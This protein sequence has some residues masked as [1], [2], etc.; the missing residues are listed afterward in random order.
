MT[1]VQFDQLMNESR[2]LTLK[3]V[4][5]VYE[6]FDE[7][8]D[9]IGFP[10]FIERAASGLSAGVVDFYDDYLVGVFGANPDD[11]LREYDYGIDWRIWLHMPT[12]NERKLPFES[13]SSD[14]V[15][16]A[17]SHYSALSEGKCGDV[18]KFARISLYA[19]NTC[20]REC[21]L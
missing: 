4:R 21:L 10:C 1:Q 3:E 6:Y 17:I 18:S 7:K 16:N 9:C 15:E 20:K 12:S 5:D 8:M 19:I 13:Y 2:P 11:F 14:D